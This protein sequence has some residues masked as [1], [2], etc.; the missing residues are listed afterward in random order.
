M[1]KKNGEDTSLDFSHLKKEGEIVGLEEADSSHFSPP[2]L[3]LLQQQSPQVN[4]T[5]DNYIE[6]AEAGMIMNR[7]NNK[8]YDGNKGVLIQPC[9]F[10]PRYFHWG[11]PDV[12]R[13]QFMGVYL[14]LDKEEFQGATAEKAGI[15]NY[16]LPNG[17]RIEYTYVYFCN[18][19]D[20]ETGEKDKVIIS[21]SRSRIKKGKMWN[22]LI[23]SKSHKMMFGSL[24]RLTTVVDRDST[25]QYSWY[26]WNIGT[27]RELLDS[28]MKAVS[29][30]DADLIEYGMQCHND[31]KSTSDAEF[32]KIGQ[33]SAPQLEGG[34]SSKSDNVAY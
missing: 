30:E 28:S 7:L 15:R 26:N 14:D 32:T 18:L 33:S 16:V 31:F 1:P 8:V 20:E 6:G 17:D 22:N 9:Y 34:T 12:K 19:I 27:E 3:V 2:L 10:A 25:G 13:G 24:Y 21:M 4:K 23:S 11:T 29:P 5:A